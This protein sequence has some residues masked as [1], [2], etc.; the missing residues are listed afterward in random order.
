MD[1]RRGRQLVAGLIAGVALVLGTGPGA[2]AASGDVVCDGGTQHSAQLAHTRV[3]GDLVVAPGTGCWLDHV[4]IAGRLVVSA[5]GATANLLSTEVA[6]DT[7]VGDPAVVGTSLFAKRS[8]FGTLT[9]Q[10]DASVELDY[11]TVRATTSGTVGIFA[12][13]GAKLGDVDLVAA[14]SLAPRG[15]VGSVRIYSTRVRGDVHSS[16]VQLM[17]SAVRVDGDLRVVDPFA[18]T[19]RAG[20]PGYWAVQLCQTV[21]VG[22]ARVVRSHGL[23]AIGAHPDGPA[24]ACDP[25]LRGPISLGTLSV[26]D[27]FHAVTVANT[28]VQGDLRCYGNSGPRGVDASGATVTGAR[29][30][31]CAS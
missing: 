25:S 28:T 1:G 2:V 12:A 24:L 9:V 11:S 17:L 7:I 13:F 29:L 3:A 8:T 5:D 18:T 30:G 15:L 4:F 23:V 26:V 16:G 6:G 31:Q 21:V 19:P 20:A 14:P 27:S 10:G 22:P